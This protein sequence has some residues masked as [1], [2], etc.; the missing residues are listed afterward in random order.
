MTDSI[1]VSRTRVYA[2]HTLYPRLEVDLVGQIWT[3]QISE[4]ASRRRPRHLRRLH[5]HAG[6]TPENSTGA[7]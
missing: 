7:V 5:A 1:P 4:L 6:M 3:R 2:A